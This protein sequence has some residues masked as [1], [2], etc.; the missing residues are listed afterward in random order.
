ML[1]FPNFNF[2]SKQVLPLWLRL[3]IICQTSRKK[4]GL[5]RPGLENGFQLSAL[6]TGMPSLRLLVRKFFFSVTFQPESSH[7]VEFI[8]TWLDAR[9]FKRQKTQFWF[10][11]RPF[12]TAGLPL[13]QYGGDHKTVHLIWKEGDHFHHQ[14]SIKDKAYKQDVEFKLGEEGTVSHNN[15]EVKF[16]YT[17]DGDKLINEVKIPSKNKIIH[18]TYVVTGDELEK[19]SFT[20]WLWLDLLPSSTFPLP[21]GALSRFASWLLLFAFADLQDQRRSSQEMVPQ[22]GSWGSCRLR[23][24]G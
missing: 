20:I 11:L 9:S 18:D 14:I 3:I 1:F 5:E 23:L 19:V 22:G 17:E 8:W 24:K 2:F 7:S 12:E 15:T 13:Q 16:R 4:N 10:S 6:R 21:L